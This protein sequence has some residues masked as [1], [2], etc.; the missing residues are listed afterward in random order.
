MNRKLAGAVVALLVVGFAVWFFA[1]RD[2][3]G[4]KKP[5]PEPQANNSG[6]AVA[7]KPAAKPTDDT[8][9]PSGMAPRWSLDVDPEGPL[10]LEGQ[11]IDEDGHGVGDAVV[12]LSSVPPRSTKTEQDGSFAFDKV[13]GREYALRAVGGNK[14]GGP[15]QYRL[16]ETS[17]PVVIRLGE[18]AKLVVTVVTTDDKPVEGAEVR[19]TGLGEHSARTTADGKATLE[20]VHPGWINVQ[21][22]ADGYAPGHGFTQIGAGGVTGTLKVRLRKGVAVSGRV[23]DEGGKPIAKARVTTVGAWDMIPS[24]EPVFTDAKGLFT[25]PALAP[26]SYTLVA[27]DGVHAPSRS[28]PVSVADRPVR[29]ITITMQQGG[30]LAGTVVDDLGQPVP[31]AT[32]R[33]AG[34][35]PQM[36]VAEARQAITDR[37]GNFEIT[38]LE[39]TKLK[40][41]A[42]SDTAASSIASVDLSTT[43][44]KKDLRLVLDVKGTIAGVVV[45]ESNEPLAEIQVN[46]FPDILGGNTPEAISLAGMS[47]SMTD[48][49]GR[50]AIRGLPEGEYRLRASRSAGGRYDWGQQGT[51]AKTGDKD[52]R[53]VLA[54]N[55]S[56]VGRLQLDSG[57][58]P[59]LASVQVGYQPSVPADTKGEFKLPE[60]APGKYDLYVRGPEFAVFV[61]RDVEVKSGQPTD[62]GTLT[63]VRGRKLVGR[64]VDASG[65]AVPGAKVK[66]GDMLFS[67]QGAE[68]QMET[69]EELYGMRSAVTD[70]DGRFTVI[71]LSKKATNVLAE[72]PTR[73]RSNTGAIPAGTEDPPPVTLTL[74]G[75]GSIVGK[76]TSKGEPVGGA[77]VSSTPKDGGAQVRFAQT[78]PD[79][80]FTVTQLTEGTH[81]VSAMQQSGFGMSLKST[82]TTV[83][84]RAGKETTVNIDIPVGSISLTVQVKPQAGAKVDSAQ[85]FLFRGTVAVA[86]A[87][88]LSEGFLAGGVQGMKFWWGAD[89]PAPEFDELVAGD[90]SVCT[91]PITGNLSDP[92]FAQRIQEHMEAL[93][94]YCKQVKLTPSPQKQTV[95]HEVPQMAPLPS[96]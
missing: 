26:G 50:F 95:V 9:P 12:W 32:V 81:V 3:G 73:G 91:I 84:V 48:G 37:T 57:D 18:A 43:P 93:G 62:V 85:V 23:I 31:F 76:V 90:Y 60:L 5:T 46:A 70:Q 10:R 65:N 63:L 96:D 52:V 33:V 61:Q 87:K 67:M 45:D 49:D 82:S 6:S 59:K 68:D 35:G 7:P 20:P 47:S 8:P 75:Y 44:E 64:V 92:Q 51:P 15:V 72:H 69:W 58:V 53:I 54:A 21:V 42:E 94:V 41:R 13:V 74:R 88:Q 38:G 16:T 39:R 56:I 79:G 55:G 34:D 14:V 29:D 71:G 27:T 4:D 1:L 78:A 17:D 40:A 24:G 66:T 30:T 19:V 36:W 28:A 25:L 22:T 77:T 86:N 11:V 2:R 80:T 83:Q 89:K